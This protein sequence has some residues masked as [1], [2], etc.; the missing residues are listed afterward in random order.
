MFLYD[1][2]NVAGR[3]SSFTLFKKWNIEIL[4]S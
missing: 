2:D 3:R 1:T 4:A